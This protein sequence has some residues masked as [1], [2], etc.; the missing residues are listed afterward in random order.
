MTTGNG[1]RRPHDK[2]VTPAPKDLVPGFAQPACAFG[3]DASSSSGSE[4][5]MATAANDDL[6]RWLRLTDKQRE[7]MDLILERKT[8]KEIARILGISK[9]AVEQRI[10]TVRAIL[11]AANRN[12]A[13]LIYARLK[14]TYDRV[15]YDPV[16]L[17]PTPKLMPSDF[18]DGDPMPVLKLHDSGAHSFRAEIGPREF[19]PPF[20]D[21]WRHDHS[22]QV[23]VMIMVGILAALVIIVFLGLGIAESLTRL[24]SN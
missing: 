6:A 11:S 10:G 22:I 3:D 8:S 18:P 4:Q 1:L 21:G 14:E 13:A 24:V 20:R 9:P 17:P 2:T 7:V 15:I 5:M 23:R 16:Q 19:L 12:E